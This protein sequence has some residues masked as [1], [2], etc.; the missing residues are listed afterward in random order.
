MPTTFPVARY[1]FA[2]LILGEYGPRNAERLPNYHRLDISATRR[3]GR[4]ELQFGFFNVYNRFNAQAIAFRQ[5][6]DS[7]IATEAVETAVFGLVPS[8]SYRW[9]F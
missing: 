7:P 3:W 4:G 6:R 9:N 8:I 2:S 1:R 5:N